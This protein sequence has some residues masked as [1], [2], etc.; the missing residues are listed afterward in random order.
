MGDRDTSYGGTSYELA[1]PEGEGQKVGGESED[2]ERGGVE[3]CPVGFDAETDVAQE[4]NLKEGKREREEHRPDQRK[5]QPEQR[6][7]GEE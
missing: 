3:E 2:G 4:V 6:R 7:H 5:R 1:E